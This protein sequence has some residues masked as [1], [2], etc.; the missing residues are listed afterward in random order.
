ML[1]HDVV[2]LFSA[3]MC[4]SV[5]VMLYLPFRLSSLI[6]GATDSHGIDFSFL[7]FV[8]FSSGGC[9]NRNEKNRTIIFYIDKKDQTTVCS[10]TECSRVECNMVVRCL[11]GTAA[12]A[13]AAAA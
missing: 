7:S 10:S 12:E 3:A 13:A 1:V 6:C 2:G 11:H 5:V 8:F 9:F 4:S